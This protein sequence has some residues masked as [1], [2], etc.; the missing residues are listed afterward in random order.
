MA[1]FTVVASLIFHAYWAVSADQQ[2]VQQL[3]FMKNLAVTGGLIMIATMG[4]GPL[5]LDNRGSH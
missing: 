2:M 5:A 3:M 4:A 1:V